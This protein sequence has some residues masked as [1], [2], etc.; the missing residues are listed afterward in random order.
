M[1]GVQSPIGRLPAISTRAIE[2]VAKL[3]DQFSLW[4][5]Q[6]AIIDRHRQ[7]TL[8]L[9]AILLD[10]IRIPA[11]DWRDFAPLLTP[12]FGIETGLAEHLTI[13]L[14]F[15]SVSLVRGYLLRRMF[16]AIR[17]QRAERGNAAR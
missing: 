17:L 10:P 5:G 8:L 14:A 3:S 9:P 1:L 2:F 15:V 11:P 16:E 7:Q 13:G 6:P 12:W 4:P